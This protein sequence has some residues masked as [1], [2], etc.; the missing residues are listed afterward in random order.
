MVNAQY[1]ESV[2]DVTIKEI[3]QMKMVSKYQISSRAQHL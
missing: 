1:A 3:L 2:K